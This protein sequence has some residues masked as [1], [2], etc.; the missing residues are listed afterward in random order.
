MCLYHSP[1]LPASVSPSVRPATDRRSQSR[2][3]SP[4]PRSVHLC[5]SSTVHGTWEAQWRRVYAYVRAGNLRGNRGARYK[6]SHERRDE[7]RTVRVPL[8]FQREKLDCKARFSRKLKFHGK[9]CPIDIECKFYSTRCSENSSLRARMHICMWYKSF[10]VPFE[11]SDER[12]LSKYF[13]FPFSRNFNNFL[14]Y[15]HIFFWISAIALITI[16]WILVWLYKKCK[17]QKDPSDFNRIP[18]MR[19]AAPMQIPEKKF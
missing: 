3:L 5:P 19:T 8:N 15:L 2:P 14:S 17:D 13:S 1:Q 16:K 12:W 9:I 11:F 10:L 4:L 7:L 18:K 6:R